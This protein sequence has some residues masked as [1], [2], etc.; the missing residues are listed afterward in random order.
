METEFIYWRHDTSVGVRVE[1]LSGCEDKSLKIWKI[2]ALQVF[3]EQG[4]DR[5][6]ELGHYPSGAPYIEDVSQRISVSHTGRFMVVASLPRTPEAHLEEFSLRTAMGI[7]AERYDRAQAL[8]VAGRVMT[9]EEISLMEEHAPELRNLNPEG[10][11]LTDEECSTAAVVLAWTIKEALYKA[12]FHEGIDFRHNL[13]IRK[14]PKVC[15]SPLDASPGCGMAL[16]R[17]EDGGDIEMKLFSYISEGHIVTIALSPK[18]AT[19]RKNGF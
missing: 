9:P 15:A 7:D 8:R 10:R 3:G 4:G 19:F 12:A 11:P 5:Y 6:R 14:F 17:R 16:I 1:E 13:V 18:C 2:M